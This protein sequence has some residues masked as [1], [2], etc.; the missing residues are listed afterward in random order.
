MEFFPLTRGITLNVIACLCFDRQDDPT[1]SLPRHGGAGGGGSDRPV[2]LP[3]QLHPHERRRTHLGA[4]QRLL[5][6]RLVSA[7]RIQTGRLSRRDTMMDGS[8]FFFFFVLM[9]SLHFAA[10]KHISCRCGQQSGGPACRTGPVHGHVAAGPGLN[11]QDADHC[12]YIWHEGWSSLTHTRREE[13]HCRC[14]T[15][16]VATFK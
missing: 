4:L 11:L 15:V 3:Q 7:L 6:A 9:V 13:G 14:G 12:D 10:N 5:A 1:G 16:P 2:G 8:P